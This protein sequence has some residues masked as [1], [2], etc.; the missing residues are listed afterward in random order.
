MMKEMFIHEEARNYVNNVVLTNCAGFNSTH[1]DAVVALPN[2]AVVVMQNNSNFDPAAM[3]K[4]TPGPNIKVLDLSGNGIKRLPAI[5]Q[6]MTSLQAFRAVENDLETFPPEFTR[7]NMN[8]L[9]TLLFMRNKITA[10]PDDIGD[11]IPRTRLMD[12]SHNRVTSIPTSIGKLNLVSLDFRQNRLTALPEEI[13]NITTLTTLLSVGG[14]MITKLPRTFGKLTNLKMILARDN[15]LTG[16]P[17]ELSNMKS[18]SWLYLGLNNITS[19]PEDFQASALGS[20]TSVDF[21][22]NPFTEV[23]RQ[24][25]D[26]PRLAWMNFEHSHVSSVRLSANGMSQTGHGMLRLGATPLCARGVAEAT[27]SVASQP[28]AATW[29][30]DCT[31][32]CAAACVSTSW[33]YGLVFDELHDSFCDVVCDRPG[34]SDGKGDQACRPWFISDSAAWWRTD[35]SA[36]SEVADKSP[37]DVSDKTRGTS[38]HAGSCKFYKSPNPTFVD[39]KRNPQ[40]LDC[41]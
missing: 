24:L 22:G 12:F 17:A 30:V 19:L 29:N 33:K 13:G 28:N 32:Q 10:L 23:P 16:I 41:L 31:P 38:H 2:V 20:L 26:A 6:N 18:L 15:R 3:R 40:H 36:G 4:G 9:K 37:P 27:A 14:N 11:K 21:S 1:W 7:G 39:C 34:C 25:T 8:N 5:V 35:C